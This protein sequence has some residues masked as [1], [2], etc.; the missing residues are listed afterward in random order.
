[1]LGVRLEIFFKEVVA[2]VA[3]VRGPGVRG[4]RQEFL[5]ALGSNQLD[6]LAAGADKRVT[7]T[8]D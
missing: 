5:K 7:L 8:G 2:A 4:I 6:A 1:L 3:Y